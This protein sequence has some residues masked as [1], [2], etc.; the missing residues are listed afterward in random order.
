MFLLVSSAYSFNCSSL[1]T[2]ITIEIDDEPYINEMTDFL[3]VLPQ[4]YS[5]HI[6]RCLSYVKSMEGNL[7]QV[8]P[9]MTEYSESKFTVPFTEKRVESREYFLSESGVINGYITYKD[10]VSYTQFVLEVDCVSLTNGD[11][12]I[13]QKCITPYYKELKS[14]GTRAY[15]ALENADMLIILVIFG[16]I[17]IVFLGMFYRKIFK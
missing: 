9:E 12:I 14:T 15:W 17:A 7:I 4:E 2:N 16:F 3:A 11:T 5:S 1:V 13:G 8:N 10:L 6:V